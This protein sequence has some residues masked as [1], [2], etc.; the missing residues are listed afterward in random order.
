MG[1][2]NEHELWNRVLLLATRASHGTQADGVSISVY[3]G[4][5][6]HRRRLQVLA[7][8]LVDVVVKHL[9]VSSPIHVASWANGRRILPPEVD[10]LSIWGTGFRIL[11]RWRLA[12]M[13][14]VYPVGAEYIQQCVDRKSP[15]QIHGYRNF[16][17]EVW[18]DSGG[19][20]PL[21]CLDG[22]FVA[23]GR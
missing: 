19:S 1:A 21:N 23:G 4:Q 9:P 20:G 12:E 6:L 11:P 14:L 15:T 10:E 5:P 8:E 3:R 22:R 2:M 13:S 17:E 16:C 18:L 7:N